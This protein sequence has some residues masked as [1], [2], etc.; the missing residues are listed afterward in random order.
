MNLQTEMDKLY[1]EVQDKLANGISILIR[2]I[3]D[4]EKIVKFLN[5]M[6]SQPEIDVLKR[7]NKIAIENEDYETC[8]A[9]KEYSKE[10]G[11]IKLNEGII[12][13]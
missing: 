9:L 4:K 5:N 10:R 12:F 13:L 6:K 3:N 2:S 8:E 11:I 1:N 7:I